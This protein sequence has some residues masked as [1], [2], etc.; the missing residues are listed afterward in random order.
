MKIAIDISPLQTGHKV[1]GVGFYLQHLKD[2]LMQFHPENTYYFFIDKKDIP[3][4]V[5]LVH[6]PYFDPFFI[7]LPFTNKHK[8]VVTVH[9]L[10][11]LVFPDHFPAGIKGSIS[12]QIQKWNLKKADAVI[13]DSESST[14]DVSRYTGIPVSRIHTVYLAAGEEFQRVDKGEIRIEKLRRKYNLP[15][16]FVLYVG[17]VTWNKNLPRLVRAIKHIN[18]PLVMVGKS[19]VQ[20]NFD[21]TNTWN[22]D[23]VEVQKLTENDSMFIKLGFIPTEDLI[24]LYNLAT[25]FA[26]PSI[27]EG[28]GLP[29]LEAM[30][31]GCPVLTTKGGSLSEITGNAAYFVDQSST[32]SIVNGITKIFSDKDLQNELKKKGLDQAKKFNWK[33]TAEETSKVYKKILSIEY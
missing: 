22:K 3:K 15:E 27:Y 17:D 20:T 5:S 26:F 9:D 1:R 6:Y 11:P 25:V 32:E 21:K 14:R 31:S 4:D 19:L 10:T 23:L 18:I 7:T 12:W 13:T 8:T 24:D 30:Q 33:K 28:F 16:K 2:A 29:V